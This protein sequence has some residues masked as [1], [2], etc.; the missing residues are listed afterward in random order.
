MTPSKHGTTTRIRIEKVR[1]A[2]IDQSRVAHT[3]GGPH[4]GLVINQQSTTG[5]YS[6]LTSNTVQC[7]A[8]VN[9]Y[10]RD[11]IAVQ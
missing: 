8:L 1:K 3:A 4:Q 7:C 10:V 9:K 5:K 11:G 6:L 2:Q